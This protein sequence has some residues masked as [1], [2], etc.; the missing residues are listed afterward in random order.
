[1]LT[2]YRRIKNQAGQWKAEKV[3]EGRGIRTGDMKGPFFVRP[4][5]NG[6]QERRA[7]HSET[8]ADAKIEAAEVETLC[9]AQSKGLTVADL[10]GQMNSNRISIK[11]VVASYLELKK[12]K[13]KKTR[14][15]YRLTLNEFLE[16]LG[17]VK[18]LDEIN[19]HVLRSYK[20]FL[21]EKGF[22]GK[23]IDTRVNIVAFLLKKNGIDA[24]VPKDE[25]PAVDIEEAVPYTEEE[26]KKMW[27]VMDKEQKI[28]YEFFLQSACRD[29]EVTFASWADIDFSKNKYH[30][31]AKPEV[32][33]TIKSHESRTV[34]LPDKLIKKLKE[35][36]KSSKSRWIFTNG[37]GE[38]ANHFLRKIKKIGLR[39]G[40]NCGHCTTTIKKGKYKWR[41]LVTVTCKTD[42]V[43]EHIYLHRFRKTCATNW[44]NTGIPVRKIQ[45]WLGHKSLEVTAKYLGAGDDDGETREQINRAAGD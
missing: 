25:M 1:M 26:L 19:V 4:M 14:Q 9:E 35:R 16:S 3:K 21:V 7:L 11:A 28:Q 5:I 30:I 44:Q 43:C 10:N 29:R 45:K 23:T 18:F 8:F 27:G 31:R 32:G 2:L 37:A 39:A 34:P 13:A 41:K 24:R 38:P 36:Q 15:Q 22:A 6:K 33:F 42:P 12:N 20:D 40:I 17:K